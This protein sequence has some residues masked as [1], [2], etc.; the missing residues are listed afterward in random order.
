MKA[1]LRFVPTP[2]EIQA[3]FER[4][5]EGREYTEKRVRKD[6]KGV[7][8]WEIAAT[9]DGDV[10]EYSYQ[11]KGRYPEVQASDTAIHAT[12]FGGEGIPVTGYR[13]ATYAAGRWIYDPL[14]S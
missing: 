7:Y 10:I 14:D 3:A 11:R 4:A 1:R 2:E 9:V 12:V 8:L 6:E 5:L 13:V